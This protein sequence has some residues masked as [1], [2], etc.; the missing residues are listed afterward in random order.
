MVERVARFEAPDDPQRVGYRFDM[1]LVVYLLSS[2][3][4]NGQVVEN[5]RQ[6]AQ[7]LLKSWKEKVPAG[8]RPS[9]CLLEIYAAD[10]LQERDRAI[11]ELRKE[12]RL[13]LWTRSVLEVVTRNTSIQSW[14][15]IFE[16]LERLGAGSQKLGAVGKGDGLMNES[17]EVTKRPSRQRA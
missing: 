16:Q 2:S 1:A 12:P 4:I 8:L 15:S 13:D 6:S 9:F 7:T 11:A 14:D 10:E 17:I 3:L 5:R